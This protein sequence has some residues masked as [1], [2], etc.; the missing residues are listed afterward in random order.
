MSAATRDDVVGLVGDVDD[1]LIERIIETGASISEI[2]EAMDD[3]EDGRFVER[4]SV[5][6]SPRVAA[7]RTILEELV[8]DEE[9]G[10]GPLPVMHDS[11]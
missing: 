4:P 8:E 6:T 5:D 3:L 7:V 2:A 11:N 10:E 9:D 1:L